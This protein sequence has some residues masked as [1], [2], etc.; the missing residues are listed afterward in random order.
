[1]TVAEQTRQDY[2]RSTNRQLIGIVGFLTGARIWSSMPSSWQDWVL[3]MPSWQANILSGTTCSLDLVSKLDGEVSGCCDGGARK[4]CASFGFVIHGTDGTKVVSGLGQVDGH[5]PNSFRAEA[6]GL[7]AILSCWVLLKRAGSLSNSAFITI[8][9]DS[10]SLVDICSRL[11]DMKTPRVD[12]NGKESD[13]LA[14]I[15][16]QVWIAEVHFKYAGS[17]AIKIE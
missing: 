5:N 3:T 11:F 6:F 14:C 1:M 17:E 4:G 15:I 8:W 12:R 16:S 7:A 9:S 13:I 2:P 10:K